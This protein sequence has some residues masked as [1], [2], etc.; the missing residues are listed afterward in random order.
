MQYLDFLMCGKLRKNSG[1]EITFSLVN[2]KTC[3]DNF[4][5]F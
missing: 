2:Y 3:S 4:E 1:S 5:I